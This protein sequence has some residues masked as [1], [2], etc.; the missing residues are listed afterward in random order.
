MVWHSV[1][2]GII[3]IK[4]KP[5]YLQSEHYVALAPGDGTIWYGDDEGEFGGNLMRIDMKSGE[6]YA[7]PDVENVTGMVKDPDRAGCILASVGL[8]HFTGNGAILR[9]CG[10][11]SEVVYKGDMPVWGLFAN[12]DGVYALMQTGV[13]PIKNGKFVYSAEQKFKDM[14]MY[15]LNDIPVTQFGN[16][17]FVYSGARGSDSVGGAGSPFVVTLP[18]GTKLKLTPVS[19]DQH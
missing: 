12:S 9:F 19:K 14:G 4:N 13:V 11:S 10:N 7:V 15:K 6:I 17:L 5:E 8:A 18:P 16:V 1:K 3:A 2:F